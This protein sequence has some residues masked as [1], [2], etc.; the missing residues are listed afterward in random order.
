MTPKQRYE[1]RKA[2]RKKLRETD[3]ELA[4]KEE[5]LEV[6]NLM[7]RIATALERLADANEPKIRVKTP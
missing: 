4:R 6:F 5:E 2:R 1:E 7:D 3:A